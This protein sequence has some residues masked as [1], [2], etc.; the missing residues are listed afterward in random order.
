MGK[1]N[2]VETSE[3]AIRMAK[4]AGIAVTALMIVGNVGET[5]DTIKQSKDFL[6]KTKPDE[7]GCTGGLWIFPGT[8][9]YG[10][11]KKQGFIDDDF[12]LTDNPYKIYTM[13]HSLEELSRMEQHLYDFNREH[14]LAGLCQSIR[15]A[16]GRILHERM[17]MTG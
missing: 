16:V 11:S 8:K 7:V 17:G 14:G 1:A 4:E 12:W 5:W 6:M 15:S 3:K 9:L 2:D 10:N 13:E